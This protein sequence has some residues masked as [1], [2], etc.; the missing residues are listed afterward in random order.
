MTS[1]EEILKNALY[2]TSKEYKTWLEEQEKKMRNDPN[3]TQL[4]EKYMEAI[5]LYGSRT[6]TSGRY[7]RTI[8]K[9]RRDDRMQERKLQ[10]DKRIAHIETEMPCAEGE[11]DMAKRYKAMLAL[12][13]GMAT[14]ITGNTVQELTDNAVKRCKAEP[15][16]SSV[17]TMP[18]VSEYAER[19]YNLTWKPKENTDKR[20][21]K[22]VH[23]QVFTHIKPYFA[24]IC[25][26]EVKT[27]D[28]QTFLNKFIVEGRSASTIDQVRMALKQV[29]DLA[30]EDD[31]LKKN[32]AVSKRISVGT[33]EEKREPLTGK[34]IASILSELSAIAPK[35]QLLILIPLYAGTRRGETL[36]LQ[37]KHVDFEKDTITIEQACKT[38]G[39]KAILGDTK[40]R[41]GHRTI[42]LTAPLKRVLMDIQGKSDDYIVSGEKLMT[43]SAYNRAWERITKHVNLYGKTAHSLRHTYATFMIDKVSNKN[44]Q[45]IMG[46]SE[47]STTMDIYVHPQKEKIAGMGQALGDI[48]RPVAAT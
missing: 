11:T 28:V 37:W 33:K 46:H 9:Q 24:N 44:L 18:T 22:N 30:I 17:G 38:N 15:P 25:L 12:E 42:P 45:Y 31:L 4:T 48:Y 8:D 35:D 27:S 10:L 34:Q 20:T 32:P 43:Q 47:F 29:F 26:D 14:W 21:W 13:N 3:N 41:A 39:N 16:V 36:G 23:T 7:K 40:S 19:W 6:L 1:K 2:G 5:E